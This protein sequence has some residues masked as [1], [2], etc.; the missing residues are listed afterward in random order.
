MGVDAAVYAA[1]QHLKSF[2]ALDLACSIGTGVK[3][4]GQFEVKEPGRVF[5]FAGEGYNA[6]RKKR[7]VAW[8]VAHGLEPYSCSAVQF[9]NRTLIT[10]DDELIEG[11]INE[12]EELLTTEKSRL[13]VID[14]KN[15]ALNGQD[16]DKSHVAAKYLNTLQKVR[17]RIGGSSLTIGHM[18]WD[19][20]R[21]RGSSA[22]WG[23][24]DT[25][26]YIDKMKKDAETGEHII[27]ILVRKQKDEDDGQR[28]FLR[29]VRAE[30]PEGDSS[31]VLEP[32]TEKEG[33]A[34]LFAEGK[35]NQSKTTPAAFEQAIREI[36]PR[37][38][39]AGTREI[40]N[41]IADNTHQKLNTVEVYLTTH[42]NPGGK[43]HRYCVR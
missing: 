7:R 30:T 4:L 16:E 23:G 33:M 14:T 43:F 2:F 32:I 1:P 18:G 20:E 28:Y 31:L 39:V 8:E 3:A 5:Y 40:A 19:G 24:F 41:R 17:E 27:S 37:G 36:R 42:R 12:V 10:S 26:F 9:A 38:G 25:I 34:A 35:A 13:F 22:F 6:M 29:A 21:Q 11:D 15:R